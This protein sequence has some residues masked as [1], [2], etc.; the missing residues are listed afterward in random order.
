MAFTRKTESTRQRRAALAILTSAGAAL[1]V[2]GACGSAG[3]ASAKLESAKATVAQLSATPKSIGLNTSL[4]K[5]PPSGKSVIY[6]GPS[7]VAAVQAIS[8]AAQAATAT[9]GWSYSFIPDGSTPTAFYAAFQ[10]ALQQH[11]SV[12]LN[13][14]GDPVANATA[15]AAAK[16]A[17]VPVVEQ[18]SVFNPTGMNGNGVIGVY[19]GGPEVKSLGGVIADWIYADS[20]GDPGDVAYLNFP[21]YSIVADEYSGLKSKMASL[22]SS[23]KVQ[24]LTA[25]L[26]DIGTNVPSEIVNAIRTNPKIKYV[27]FP[28]GGAETGVASALAAAG[29]TGVKMIGDE[30]AGP[31]LA[32]IS[33]G[34]QTMWV[35]LNDVE[36]GWRMV[37]I[38]AR[39]LA[40]DKPAANE[41]I[42]PMQIFTKANITPA[43]ISNWAAAEQTSF[44]SQGF[45]AQF[46]KLWK[47]G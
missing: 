37:D 31:E 42:G 6:V 44:D 26:S 19:D 39:Y 33:S 47:V 16:A 35:Q 43:E 15:I 2:A 32:A 8:N 17:G 38:A 24:E 28:F 29:I 20:N 1:V 7:G 25:Q 14:S 3:A 18:A 13:S 22:C 5:A 11:P 4:T 21:V 41:G 40:G 12:I 34:Q 23:C 9:L 27:D 45:P 30:G 10:Q 36:T 46:K